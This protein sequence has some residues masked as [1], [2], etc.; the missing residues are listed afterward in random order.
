MLERAVR[1]RDDAQIEAGAESVVVV[2]SGI[3]VRFLYNPTIKESMV[4][5]KR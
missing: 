2:L 3:A 5:E 4:I 1:V